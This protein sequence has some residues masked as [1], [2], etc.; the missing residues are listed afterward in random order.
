MDLVSSVTSN[1]NSSEILAPFNTECISSSR[2]ITINNSV[3]NLAHKALAFISDFFAALHTII[4]E[5]IYTPFNFFTNFL[6]PNPPA[7]DLTENTQLPI[8]FVH[9]YGDNSTFSIPLRC[10]LRNNN[11]KGAFYHFSYNI[12]TDET[13]PE[14]SNRLAQLILTTKQETGFDKVLIFGHSLGGVIGAY[15]KEK[16]MQ[17]SVQGIFTACSPVLGTKTAFWGPDNA[18]EDLRPGSP[19]LDELNQLIINSNKKTYYQVMANIDC[20][21]T[22]SSNSLHPSIPSSQQIV[23]KFYGHGSLLISPCIHKKILH[24]FNKQ[25]NKYLNNNNR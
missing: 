17:Q 21:I 8:I 24:F 4:A 9:G 25:S 20:I 7:P 22:P 3:Q 5:I 13:I 18:S 2:K 10:Y 16:Y 1:I 19:F 11:Y 14:Y 12:L 15:A 6:E 23:T